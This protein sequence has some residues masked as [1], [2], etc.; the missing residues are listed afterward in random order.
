MASIFI[1]ALHQVRD[2]Q[3]IIY[4]GDNCFARNENWY[5]FFELVNIINSDRIFAQTISSTFMSAD[6]I[7]TDVE[8][9]T[10]FRKILDIDDFHRNINVHAM[11]FSDFYHLKVQKSDYQVKRA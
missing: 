5:P 4:F 6:S 7:H 2:Y 8:K 9:S 10:K 1:K 3:Q 11:N